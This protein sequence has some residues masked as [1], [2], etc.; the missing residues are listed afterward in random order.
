MIG[1]GLVAVE[2]VEVCKIVVNVGVFE[3]GTRIVNRP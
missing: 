3:D 1:L 2:F